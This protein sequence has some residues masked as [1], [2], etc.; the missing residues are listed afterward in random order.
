MH[1][2]VIYKDATVDLYY[3]MKQ[4]ESYEPCKNRTEYLGGSL[5]TQEVIS[6]YF[7]M[8]RNVGLS[9]TPRTPTVDGMSCLDVASPGVNFLMKSDIAVLIMTG[10]PTDAIHGVNRLTR[11]SC[12]LSPCLSALFKKISTPSDRHRGMTFRPPWAFCV[13]KSF[14]KTSSPQLRLLVFLKLRGSIEDKF[15]CRYF[16]GRVKNKN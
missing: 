3:F 16:W 14:Q 9:Q 2:Y 8:A 12:P 1:G 5:L 10:P 6:F 4:I 15:P 7:C 11:T 13:L